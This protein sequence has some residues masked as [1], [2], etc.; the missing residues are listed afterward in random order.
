MPL[1]P[2]SDIYPF[3]CLSQ[4]QNK[5]FTLPTTIFSYNPTNIA[6][7]PIH[8]PQVQPSY[9]TAKAPTHFYVT[10]CGGYCLPL[11]DLSMLSI[12]WILPSVFPPIDSLDTPSQTWPFLSG[13]V[14][15]LSVL[16]LLSPVLDA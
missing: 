9:T 12:D 13:P 2:S 15:S 11:F 10:K 4:E 8:P 3:I 5:L 7:L 14:V 1:S 6:S 16:P